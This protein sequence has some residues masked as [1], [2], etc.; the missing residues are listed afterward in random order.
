MD[1][2]NEGEQ[3]P[4][5]LWL[6]RIGWMV[7]LWLGGVTSLALVAFVLKIVMRAAGMR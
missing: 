4:P 2:S 5:R 3:R 6:R 1:A 7:L